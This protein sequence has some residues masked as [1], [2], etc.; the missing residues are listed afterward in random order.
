MPS[1]LRSR[2]GACVVVLA[3][4][5]AARVFAFAG[6]F[7]FF[8][9][10]DEHR[11]VDGVLKYA[12][13]YA[14]R[15]DNT[16]YESETAGY[17]GMFGSPEYHLR[18]GPDGAAVAPPPPWQRPS[19]AM[20]R[21]LERSEEFLARRTNLEA[22]QP[23]AYYAAAALWLQVGRAIGL[24]GGGLL[25]WVRGLAVPI[26]FALVWVSYC[27]ARR[28][29]PDDT[30]MRLGVPLLLAAFPMDLFFYVTRDALSPLIAGLGY[31]LALRLIMTP[32]SSATAGFGNGIVMAAAFLAKYTNAALLVACGI[33]TFAAARRRPDARRFRGE[34]GRLLV[35]WTAI[36]VPVGAWLLRNQVVF[37]DIT[38]TTYKIERMG[39]GR[40]DLSEYFDHPIFTPAGF[41]T[42][43]SELVPLFWRGELAWHRIPLAAPT[44]DLFYTLTTLAF[45]VLAVLGLRRRDRPDDRR[46]A[47]GLAVLLVGGYVAILA[48]LSPL[49]V[50]HETS[51]PSAQLPYFV[52][53]RL[54]SGALVPFAVMYV[55]GAQV[56]AGALPARFASPA[57][58]ALLGLAVAVAIVS[59]V[60]L[61]VPVFA[62]AYNLFHL[63]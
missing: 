11:H 5:A 53:G 43:V 17:L 18:D 29:Y 23:P 44:A 47:E 6:A 1:S 24:Q 20:L 52:Q 9:N 51:N 45:F 7:P 42:F 41:G 14:P 62:S 38:A 8:T 26:V 55:R 37:G 3:A 46:F 40:R 16:G 19:E 2:E 54:I 36:A 63:P 10:V 57:A 27:F 30:F 35:M 61:H 32:L 50:F 33:C 15:P 13:G 4:L 12:R 49:Y 58:W 39:W 25:Y 31:W 34:G 21:R 48:G 56:A 59:E 28:I 22:M 60:A